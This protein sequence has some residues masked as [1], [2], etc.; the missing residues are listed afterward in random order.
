M[1][2]F[3]LF[4][5]NKIRKCCW[6]SVADFTHI[7]WLLFFVFTFDRSQALMLRTFS[8]LCSG[9]TSGS[10]C[11]T[12]CCASD[13]AW[14]AYKARIFLLYHFSIPTH[15]YLLQKAGFIFLKKWLHSIPSAH[16]SHLYP[17]VLF[18][19]CILF[20]VLGTDKS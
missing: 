6:L 9:I 4:H 14:V 16:I 10:V 18:W 20:L 19:A 12:L 8:W 11:G 1:Y 13:L 2:L 7:V 15:M 17:V 3:L 5:L